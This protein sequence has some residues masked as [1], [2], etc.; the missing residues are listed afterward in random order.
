MWRHVA[1]ELLS[2]S[3]CLAGCVAVSRSAVLLSGETKVN[4]SWM[5]VSAAAVKHHSPHCSQLKPRGRLVGAPQRLTFEWQS[6]WLSLANIEAAAEHNSPLILDL[7]VSPALL[8]VWYIGCMETVASH[9]T[10]LTWLSS[11]S[12]CSIDW[13][14]KMEWA[15]RLALFHLSLKFSRELE[16]CD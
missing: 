4:N 2:C 16:P 11:W 6:F 10:V 3:C 8:V 1:A 12:R 7:R 9:H 5:G 15:P 13:K 14:K